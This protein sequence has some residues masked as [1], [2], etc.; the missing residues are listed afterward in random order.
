MKWY[1]YRSDTYR[2]IKIL[3]TE[4]TATDFAQ[5]GNLFVTAEKLPGKIEIE[6]KV[7]K[8]GVDPLSLTIIWVYEDDPN[9]IEIDEN[10]TDDI[11]DV[12][13]MSDAIQSK[14]NK[15]KFNIAYKQQKIKQEENAINNIRDGVTNITTTMTDKEL[16]KT[17]HQK[18]KMTNDLWDSVIVLGWVTQA[19]KTEII[20]S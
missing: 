9:Y 10:L 17:W 4:P 8:L 11:Q 15:V 16:I 1:F 14:I 20:K 6:G 12:T 19:E 3:S 18:G 7:S 13:T 5:Y 2:V